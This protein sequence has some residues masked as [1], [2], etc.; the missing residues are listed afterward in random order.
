MSKDDD[1]SN[2]I[3]IDTARTVQAPGEGR[4]FRVNRAPSCFHAVRP[5]P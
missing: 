3:S 1:T 5:G 2:V 4:L